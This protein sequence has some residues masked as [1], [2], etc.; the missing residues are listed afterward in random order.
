MGALQ[1]HLQVG[2]P[3]QLLGE[4]RFEVGL[5]LLHI[6]TISQA[7]PLG[8][9]AGGGGGGHMSMIRGKR[10]HT[11]ACTSARLPGLLCLTRPFVYLQRVG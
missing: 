2:I 6:L 11:H 7:P 8:Q 1:P 10:V 4:Q 9:P 3:P 5:C